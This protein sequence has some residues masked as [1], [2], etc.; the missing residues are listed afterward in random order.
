MTIRFEPIKPAIGA[1][2]YADSRDEFFTKEAAQQCY[3]ALEKYTVLVFPRMNLTDEEQ[4]KFTDLLG[5]RINFNRNVPGTN[6]TAQDIYKV[7]LDKDVNFQPEYVLGT[8]FWHMDGITVPMPPPKATLLSAR[9]VAPKGGQTEFCSTLSAYDALPEEDKKDLEGLRIMHK[10]RTSLRA[11]LDGMTEEEQSKLVIGTDNEH[12]IV[13]KRASGRRS[14][15]IGS[16]ADHVVG[17]G[18]AQGRA[19]IARLIEWAA[20]PDFYYRHYWEPGDFVIWDNCGSMHRVV[21]YDEDSGRSM[22][23]TSIAGFEAVQ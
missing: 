6:A 23:R 8:F 9:K 19:L 1:R 21:P 17:M 22:H 20:Q 18:F 11:M 15:V 4:L 16:H 7:T 3:D 10:T 13:W 14:L 5:G 12:P 2:V